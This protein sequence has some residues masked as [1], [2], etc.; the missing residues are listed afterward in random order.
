MQLARKK[1]MIGE[2]LIRQ[3]KREMLWIIGL[4]RVIRNRKESKRYQEEV[5]KDDC[6]ITSWMK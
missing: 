3:E 1:N 2:N 6:L 5:V 4:A